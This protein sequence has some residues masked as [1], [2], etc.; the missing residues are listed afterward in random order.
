MKVAKRHLQ[1]GRR[2]EPATDDELV[3]LA[4]S[5]DS[6]TM[7]DQT[8]DQAPDTFQTPPSSPPHEN[9][10]PN[11]D[12]LYREKV[13]D[14]VKDDPET[15]CGYWS[16]RPQIL[17][18][19][20]NP[21]CLLLFLSFFSMAQGFVVNGINNVS[22]TSVERRFQL[23]S[24][25]VGM[26][27]SSYDLSAA[28]LGIFISFM[29]SGRQKA[30]WL[31]W[32]CLSMAVGS[33]IMAMPHF[34]SGKYEWGQDISLAC[35][36][37]DSPVDCSSDSELQHY[38]YVLI[39]G[40]LLHGLGGTTLYTVGVSLIDD[41]VPASSSP[42]YIGILYAFATLG[43]AMGYIIGGQLLEIYV[44]FDTVPSSD[45]RIKSDDP[46]WVGA[47]WIGFII[48]SMLF[49]V[50][51]VPIS[52]F[53]A[54]LPSAKHVRETRVSEM[55]GDDGTMISSVSS[56]GRKLRD[57]KFLPKQILQL[58]KTPPFLFITLA[59]ATEGMITSGFAT[60][61]PKFIQNQFGVSAGWAAMLTGFMAVPGAAGGQ[62]FGGYLC[63]CLKL[64]VKGCIRVAIICSSCAVLVS[65]VL[66]I[67]CNPGNVAGV[68]REYLNSTNT[69]LPELIHTCNKDCR[70]HTELY[71]PVCDSNGVQ[72]FSP[73]HAGCSIESSNSE[74]Y[75]SCSCTAPTPE[76]NVSMVTVGKC[77]DDC[78]MLYVFMPMIFVSIFLLFVPSP[79]AVAAT[80]RCI[81][82]SHRTLGLGLKWFI[83]RLLGTVPGPILFGAIIDNTCVIW[84]EKCGQ[85]A[86][87]WIYN[88][89]KLSL[90]FF[91]FV[92][93]FK[94]VSI[95]FFVLAHQMYKPPSEKKVKYVVSDSENINSDSVV[96]GVTIVTESDAGI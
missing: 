17:Q 81:H 85:R 7:E 6:D 32:G 30:K 54:E 83:V 64:K 43:P 52:L 59:G 14:K 33:F 41:S 96:S 45:V 10:F 13:R 2:S 4:L 60:F 51:A 79:P 67:R 70:C 94:L 91:I 90:N 1:L 66:W 39:L 19:C 75:S 37:E 36:K 35:S 3:P 69:V 68:S 88:N 74:S 27:S 34:T 9:G 5:T 65:S 49:I 15:R 53:G 28:I 47:W 42:M 29:G 58:L 46:R 40:Q 50:A 63:K 62:F 80:L 48:A 18:K 89:D 22:T 16:C 24:S 44:D 26:I 87:C 72:Y 77:E 73:C 76:T 55:H 84:R 82:D 93:C 57:L 78:K 25:R 8:I 21:K 23:P 12:I 38:L 31:A 56:E 86:S 61:M 92:V 20:N 11:G 71:E 95:T